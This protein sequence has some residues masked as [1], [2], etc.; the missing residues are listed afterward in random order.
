MYVLS[1]VKPL[2]NSCNEEVQRRSCHKSKLEFVLEEMYSSASAGAAANDPP[3][4]LRL[5]Q[6]KSPPLPTDI[7]IDKITRKYLTSSDVHLSAISAGSTSQD[8]SLGHSVLPVHQQFAKDPMEVGAGLRASPR[9][10]PASPALPTDLYMEQLVRKYLGSDR[11]SGPMAVDE[12]EATLQHP[13]LST[14]TSAL[15]ALAGPPSQASSL[16]LES[17]RC[18]AD[19]QQQRDVGGEDG[20]PQL[21]PS[22]SSFRLT[23]KDIPPVHL[24]S[25]AVYRGLRPADEHR[26]ADGAAAQN[27]MTDEYVAIEAPR[28]APPR[29][30]MTERGILVS[31][32]DTSRHSNSALELQPET[33]CVSC[34][35]K[36]L[37]IEDSPDF[38]Q[39]YLNV[40]TAMQVTRHETFQLTC[41]GRLV[42]FV[43]LRRPSNRG[44]AFA[45]APVPWHVNP[46]DLN[47]NREV[48]RP[49]MILLHYGTLCRSMPVSARGSLLIKPHV[50]TLF[51]DK[52]VTEI[53]DALRRLA[54]LWQ[55]MP[56]HPNVLQLFRVYYADVQVPGWRDVCPG[57]PVFFITPCLTGDLD[58]EAARYSDAEPS[59][60]LFI[61][62]LP[63]VFLQIASALAHL[64]ANN[65]VHG[66]VRCANVF[67]R[68]FPGSIILGNFGF[69][70]NLRCSHKLWSSHVCGKDVMAPELMLRH[71][72]PTALSDTW[73]IGMMLL[74]CLDWLV[75]KN[76]NATTSS[77][78]ARRRAMASASPY[79]RGVQAGDRV[80]ET[81][82]E[83]EHVEADDT[84]GGGS[85]LVGSVCKIVR[86]RMLAAEWRQDEL[87]V[88]LDGDVV[89]AAESVGCGL[90]CMLSRSGVLGQVMRLCLRVLPSERML[91]ANAVALMTAALSPASS[92]ISRT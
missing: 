43:E 60:H 55:C 83:E 81:A 92:T 75:A 78:N 3:H 16:R 21:P 12:R 19:I 38:G 30:A 59:R 25:A 10:R 32:P 34:Q 48:K 9:A 13:F 68:D 44:K 18:P 71:S 61:S 84:A 53:Y 65:I 57:L 4:Q 35:G 1:K 69:M 11:S 17:P 89:R 5:S 20:H 49:G 63:H 26:S 58:E 56:A 2:S 8:V 41:D 88:L 23:P 76:N 36:L 87:D 80:W 72:E 31:P 40:R 22:P 7:Q 79:A 46:S 29:G 45:V 52:T 67:V 6:V 70:P 27:S 50:A 33:F 74:E 28:R 64:H 24:S 91:P 86:Q 62:H 47:L 82:Q 77:P 73:G 90:D 37:Y 51:D 14:T 39:F 42:E 66:D 85:S 54:D 15:L